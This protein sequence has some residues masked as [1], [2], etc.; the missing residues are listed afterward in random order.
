[1][2][3]TINVC[4]ATNRNNLGSEKAPR[5]GEKFHKDGPAFYRVGICQVS[6]LERDDFRLDRTE[7]NSESKFGSDLRRA[8]HGSKAAFTNIQ[9][10]MNNETKDIIVFIHGFS[11]TFE[12]GILRAAQL[13]GAYTI[14]R[15]NGTTYQPPVF[16][17][18]WPSNGRT[19]PPWQYFSDRNDAEASGTA[20]ARVLLRLIDFLHASRKDG[21]QC[22]RRLHLVC[23]SMGN[24]AL[25]HMLQSLRGIVGDNGLQPVFDN[26]FL[27]AADEDDDALEPERD[28]KLGLLPKLGRRIHVYHSAD[29]E[30]LV[31]SDKTKLNPDRLGYNG[32]RHFDGLC[33]RITA[34]D[35]ELVDKTEFFHVNHQY[36]RLRKEVIKD[37]RAILSGHH[38]ADPEAFPWREVIER[39]RRYRI[40]LMEPE[41]EDNRN[42]PAHSNSIRDEDRGRR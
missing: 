6:K 7:L 22:N 32:P 13:S 27:M 23:H 28:Q 21:T 8:R 11:N 39:G 24:W 1:M 35:C 37:V 10:E 2:A 14:T 34:I 41:V 25:R 42:D 19:T 31:I 12:S 3:E 40:R 36:Y 4:F 16:A 26:I 9:T 17:F 33:T 5:F 30:A 18:S 29:D 15:P 20:M 38:W